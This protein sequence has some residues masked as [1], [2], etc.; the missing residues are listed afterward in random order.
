MN[1]VLLLLGC[2][3]S[4]NDMTFYQNPCYDRQTEKNNESILSFQILIIY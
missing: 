3:E 2:E 1:E 4:N